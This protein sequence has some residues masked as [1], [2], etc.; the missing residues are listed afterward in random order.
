MKQTAQI[1]RS[2]TAL[3]DTTRSIKTETQPVGIKAGSKP[4]EIKEFLDQYVIGQEE[5]KRM[6]AIAVSNHLKRINR[7][8][9][10]SGEVELQKSNLLLIGPTG[11]GK[12]MLIESISKRIDVPVVIADATAMTQTGYWGDDATDMLMKLYRI[13]GRD[14]KKT[15]R[16]IIYIDEI[17]KLRKTQSAGRD[18]AGQGVQECLLKMLEGAVISVEEKSNNR[19]K[20]EINTRNILFICGGA[21]VG[22]RKGLHGSRYNQVRTEDLIEYGLTPEFVARLPLIAALDSLD[23]QALSRILTEPKNAILKQYKQLLAID[24][25]D[26]EFDAAAVQ[27]IVARAVKLGTGARAL[28]TIVDDVM[29][30]IMYSAPNNVKLRITQEMVEK[31]HPMQSTPLDKVITFADVAGN[32]DAKA[33]LLDI[34]RCFRKPD[35]WQKL[36]PDLPKGVLLTGDPGN[37]KTLLARAVAGESG[38]N[39]LSA[40]G[41]DFVEIW[42]CQGAQ[43]VRELF[44]KARE[45]AP[46]VVFIDEIDAVGKKRSSSAHN[47]S[48]EYEQTLNA[49]LVELDGFE[50]SDGVVV[51]AATNRPDTLDDAL[52]RP[53]RFDRHVTVRLRLL[54]RASASLN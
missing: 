5:A 42:V 54:R 29:T 25:C 19:E 6:L 49:L 40:A 38:A 9:N 50:A 10:D 46:C 20:I 53:G 13:S 4:V 39:F 35:F 15:E 2:K 31:A 33:D 26:L 21:F 51:I 1:K 8:A 3:P 11:S 23:Q 30:E 28:R 41:S 24:K 7:C 22:I 16:G 17:D 37:G 47:G 14:I 32:D 52:T 45:K 48:R 18:L 36:L 43:R 44:A 34:V 27:A 12:T